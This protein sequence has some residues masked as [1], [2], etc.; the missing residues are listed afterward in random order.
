MRKFKVTFMLFLCIGFSVMIKGNVNGAE[1]KLSDQEAF[2]LL[3]V[4][5]GIT[6]KDLNTKETIERINRFMYTY[7]KYYEKGELTP[8]ELR[9]YL[10]IVYIAYERANA[11]AQEVISDGILSKFDKQPDLFL[12]TLDVRNFLVPSTCRAIRDAYILH[13]EYKDAS[14]FIQKYDK[15]LD[16]F[17]R[18]RE[19]T[20]C[21]DILLIK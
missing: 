19:R 18:I 20:A 14:L 6:S 2:V 12:M 3:D 8:E 16:Q 21:T 17:L 11:H 5:L 15:K 7:Q 4:L 13:G 1:L 9:I 10:F